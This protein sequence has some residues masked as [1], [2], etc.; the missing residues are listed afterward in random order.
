MRYYM[1]A[2]TVFWLATMIASNL[3]ARMILYTFEERVTESERI[4]IARVDEVAEGKKG[5]TYATVSPLRVIKGVADKEKVQIKYGVPLS[6]D[7][8]A[9]ITLQKGDLYLLFIKRHDSHS[10]IVGADAGYFGID[11]NNM[12]SYGGDKVDVSELI[13]K[14]EATMVKQQH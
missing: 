10:I 3:Q 9:S 1:G 14:I 5:Y 12:V 8:E 6:Y 7:D 2:F 13:K 11:K 4:I